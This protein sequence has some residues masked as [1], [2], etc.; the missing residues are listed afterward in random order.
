MA[1]K[2]FILCL[3]LVNLFIL[4]YL[5]YITIWI[6]SPAVGPEIPK[7]LLCLCVVIFI[8]LPIVFQETIP[9]IVAKIDVTR[10]KEFELL[11]WKQYGS[12][13]FY[14]R[15][16]IIKAIVS[17]IFLIAAFKLSSISLRYSFQAIVI[18][19]Y[20]LFPILSIIELFVSY[21]LV[22]SV[23]FKDNQLNK[24]R[25]QFNT[26]L[27][28]NEKAQLAI[29]ILANE[30]Y[31]DYCT[32]LRK[33]LITNVNTHYILLSNLQ[34]EHIK[35]QNPEW[36]EANV[37]G[38]IFILTKNNIEQITKYIEQIKELIHWKLLCLAIEDDDFIVPAQLIETINQ[39]GSFRWVKKKNI[40]N[41]LDELLEQEQALS[42]YVSDLLNTFDNN[43]KSDY[44]QIGY[45][46]PMLCRFWKQ[47]LFSSPLNATL[48]LFDLIDMQLRS[49]LYYVLL[50]NG[51]QIDLRDE[52]IKISSFIGLGKAII[53]NNKN[54]S[55]NNNFREIFNI[56]ILFDSVKDFEDCFQVEL[57]DQD[58]N[59]LGLVFLL[60]YIRNK[61]RGHGVLKEEIIK[62]V[63]PILFR[64]AVLINHYLIL[65]QLKL[66]IVN[67]TPFI[68]FAGD[69]IEAK[70]F[71]E[72][73][74]TTSEIVLLFS[75]DAK[76]KMT[77][78][79]YF[80]GNFYKP[81]LLN[82]TGD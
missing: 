69:S 80:N 49:Y 38:L 55:I 43:I 65:N 56:D 21:S 28:T 34:Y 26:W 17:I 37:T 64:M 51:K 60:N 79:D 35:K 4:I 47:I 44:F 5:S 20:Y 45:S 10:K 52:M 70:P 32:F 76:N 72:I 15:M 81:T 73:N 3:R 11:T 58:F 54:R 23:L 46:Q 13:K 68:T 75:I 24:L 9:Q 48:M 78:I 74:D 61:T 50:K 77:Y 18:S 39:T 19:T 40:I 41:D 29:F 12:Y 22:D 25:Y 6:I 14:F 33:I 67:Q 31:A 7:K 2:P 36:I 53:D 1:K 57:A 16:I 63:L 30:E 66:E 59:F 27:N 82:K 8:F 62:I 71:I 42:L